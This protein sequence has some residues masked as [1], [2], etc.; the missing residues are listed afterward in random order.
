M[1]IQI[2]IIAALLFITG[3]TLWFFSPKEKKAWYQSLPDCRCNNPDKNGIK[4]QDGWSK[5]IGNIKEFHKGAKECF[6]SYPAIKTP[7]GKSGQQCCY[8]TEGKLI[9]CGSGAG[10]PDK[11]STCNGEDNN[12]VMTVRYSTLIG[13]YLKDVLPFK[14]AGSTNNAWKKY[15][16]EWVPSKGKNCN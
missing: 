3:V 2:K 16:Q 13:H 11:V 9:S 12:G 14:K 4:L 7:E 6:R 5:D 1:G 15:N 10:T 8:N